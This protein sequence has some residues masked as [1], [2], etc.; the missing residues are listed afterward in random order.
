MVIA[1]VHSLK[2]GDISRRCVESLGGRDPMDME[3]SFVRNVAVRKDMMRASFR[4][5]SDILLSDKCR[6]KK[7]KLM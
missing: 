4:L 5:T 2:V 1:L 6:A 7:R 3:V